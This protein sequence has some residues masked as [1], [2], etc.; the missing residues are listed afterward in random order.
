MERFVIE[1]PDKSRSEEGRFKVELIPGR[2]MLTDGVNLVRLGATIEPRSLQGW[3]YTFYEVTGTG[4]AM[5]T[6][7]APPEGAPK[8][9][10]FISGKPLLIRYNSRLPVVIYAPKGY[11]IRYRIW[12]GDSEM[13]RA[14]TR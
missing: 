5:S 1:L 8:T 2:T 4:P 14:K 11:E 13:R 12:K 10:R 9:E 7:M 3:G 6:M